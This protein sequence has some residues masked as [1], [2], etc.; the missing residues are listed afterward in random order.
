LQL[1]TSELSV[2]LGGI[3]V[4]ANLLEEAISIRLTISK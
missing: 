1:D 4:N 3:G 2:K